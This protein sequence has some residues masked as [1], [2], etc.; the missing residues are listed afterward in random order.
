MW[1]RVVCEK[2]Q[3]HNAWRA[4][5]SGGRTT[6]MERPTVKT[7]RVH[8]SWDFQEKSEDIFIQESVR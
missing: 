4:F 6:I 7:K 3:F 5:I 2:L 1:P 8:I